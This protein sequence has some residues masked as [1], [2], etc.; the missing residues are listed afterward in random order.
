MLT[1]KPVTL[2]IAWQGSSGQEGSGTVAVL[3]STTVVFE[4]VA[5]PA[6]AP[7][8]ATRSARQPASA[9]RQRQ[10]TAI[11][12]DPA[13]TAPCEDLDMPMLLSSENLSV[14]GRLATGAAVITA[15]DGASGSRANCDATA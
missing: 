4:V 2:P 1:W 15:A 6:L 13:L 9:D 12:A 7:T 8:R 3:P 5:A 14:R 10:A 11:P